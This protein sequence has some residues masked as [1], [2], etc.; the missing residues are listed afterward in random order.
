[1]D[2]LLAFPPGEATS[3]F[4][5]SRPWLVGQRFTVDNEAVRQHLINEVEKVESFQSLGVEAHPKILGSFS[6]RHVATF[7]VRPPSTRRSANDRLI[8]NFYFTVRRGV[9]IQVSKAIDDAIV[10]SITMDPAAYQSP[11]LPPKHD[12]NIPYDDIRAKVDGL[13]WLD[14]VNFIGHPIAGIIIN[15]DW[16]TDRYEAPRAVSST[17]P[18]IT[19]TVI[20]DLPPVTPA[21]V[22][23]G[24]PFPI[25]GQ[26]R[27]QWERH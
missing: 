1:V 14:L 3:L 15:E 8:V 2:P 4:V 27:L 11:P 19:R 22:D 18:Q 7:T 25:Y 24:Q 5:I 13:F 9:S 6:S 16:V 12:W 20:D 26:M 21:S 17:G 10:V 23:D